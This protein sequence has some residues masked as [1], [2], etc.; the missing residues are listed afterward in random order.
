[1]TAR[2][3][4]ESRATEDDHL[5]VRVWLRMLACANLIEGRVSGSLRARFDTTLPRF[6]FLSQL[7]RSADGLRMSEISRRMMV[8]GGNITRV[9][10]QLESEG[11]IARSVP[12]DDR[13]ASI[14]R[15][16]DVGRRAFA[17]MAHEHEA[18]IVAMFG[19]LHE[20]ERTQLYALLAKLKRH[21][22]ASESDAAR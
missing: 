14:V 4:S 7:E 5:S 11:L 6:D 18:W 12:A 17:Q 3:D 13:R 19:G 22:T 8:T 10:E 15:L 20:T 1:M 21:L 16:T 9:A 2:A